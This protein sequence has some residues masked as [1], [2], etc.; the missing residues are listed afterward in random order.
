MAATL[1][2]VRFS[3]PALDFSRPQR[4]PKLGER[5]EGVGWGSPYH[6]SFRLV[7]NPYSVQLSNDHAASPI[8]PI[9]S[10]S[11]ARI[12]ALAWQVLYHLCGYLLRRVD[13]LPR[14]QGPHFRRKGSQ[15]QKGTERLKARGFSGWKGGR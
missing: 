13:A 12:V 3:L 2:A 4:R 5:P 7:P 6:T 15:E 11:Q 9:L 14:G 1:G 10:C 8:V